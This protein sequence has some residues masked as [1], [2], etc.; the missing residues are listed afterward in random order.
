[1]LL[2]WTDKSPTET[3]FRIE[4]SPVTDTHFTE[5]ATVGANITSFTD[6]GLSEAT[7]YWYRVRAYNAYTTSDYSGEK[8]V[9]TLYNIPAAPSGLTITSLLTSLVTFS[10]TDNSGDESHFKI[11][12]KTGATGTYALIVTTAANVTS[13]GDYTVKDGTLYYYRVS[14]TN[15]AGDSAFSNEASGMTLLKKP[16]AAT[17]TAVSSSQ[18]NV[19]WIDNSASETGYKIERKK[20][21]T[22]TYAQ[23]AQ[24]GANVQSYHDTNGLDHNT[25]YYYRVRAT[26]GTIDSDYSNQP[27]ATTFP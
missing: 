17:A 14:A 23:I 20:T 3:G 22:G 5:I 1:M 4:R 10:W 26:N 8:S 13:R 16:T 11:Y 19:A 6:T 27:F 25:R 9:T 7:K 21:A 18:I 12:R 2:N 15:A 24:V